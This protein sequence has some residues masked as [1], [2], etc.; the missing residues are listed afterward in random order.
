MWCCHHAATVVHP[1]VHNN[2]GT[3]TPILWYHFS[4]YN[5]RSLEKAVAPN[6]A[7]E[8]LALGKV[9]PVSPSVP[10]TSHPSEG[11]NP[12]PHKRRASAELPAPGPPSS[13]A[14]KPA[15]D[16]DSEVEVEVE[17]RDECKQRT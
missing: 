8:P 15:G 11:A 4:F 13:A 6:V 7:L 3:F 2:H 5:Y 17:S 10:S 16:G 14:S 12:K 1:V 9:A